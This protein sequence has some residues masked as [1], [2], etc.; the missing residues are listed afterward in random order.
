MEIDLLVKALVNQFPYGVEVEVIDN[1]SHFT[2]VI[3]NPSKRFDNHFKKYYNK[4]T[5]E[6]DI[7]NNEYKKL[8]DLSIVLTRYN[9]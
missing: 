1:I 8:I 3:H 5:S 9:S 2:L 7:Y 6:I 4:G